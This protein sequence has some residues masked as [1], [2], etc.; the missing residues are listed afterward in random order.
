VSNHSSICKY[1]SALV[2]FFIVFVASTASSQ[3]IQDPQAVAIL[4]SCINAAGGAS[5]V[6]SVSDFSGTG[7]T[8]FYWTG[9]EVTANATLKG[10]G[11]QQFRVDAS[12]PAGTRSWAISYGT[13]VLVDADGTRSRIPYYNAINIGIQIWPLPDIL[14]ILGDSSVTISNLGL[15]QNEAG[16]VYQI[17]TVRTDNENPDPTLATIQSVDYL[18]DPNTF[19]LLGTVNTTYSTVD[20]NQAYRRVVLFSDFRNQGTVTISFAIA[21]IISG[22]K[23]WSAQLSSIAFNVG[24]SDADFKL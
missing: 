3:V 19:M 17:H 9:S 18:V 23:T 11:T 20:I 13:G 6:T 14:A 8:V 15:V 4:S 1:R 7:T 10:R 21:E 24:L 16:Q 2:S 12:L 22:Q 5:A